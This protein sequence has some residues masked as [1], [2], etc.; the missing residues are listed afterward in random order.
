VFTAFFQR[1]YYSFKRNFAA[2]IMPLAFPLIFLF[3]FLD[4]AGDAEKAPSLRIAIIEGQLPLVVIDSLIET[5]LIDLKYIAQDYELNNINT[6][7]FDAILVSNYAANDDIVS[8]K[9]NLTLLTRTGYSRWIK[10]I[11]SQVHISDPGLKELDIVEL[12]STGNSYIAFILPGLF[13]MILIQLATTST[14]NLILSD[15]QDGTLR[16]I[17]SVK[18]SIFPLFSAEI[19][20]RFIFTM[21]CY[22][23]IALL[24]TQITDFLS[25][26]NFIQFTAV[27]ILG[28]FMMMILGFALGGV[29]PGQRNWSV[30]ITLL[31]LSFWFFSDILFVASQH[32]F[33]K[34][35]SL[36]LPPT[37][38]VDALRQIST[39]EKGTFS[40]S[41]DIGMIIFWIVLLSFISIKFFRY[42]TNDN[43]L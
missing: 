9:D 3:L 8:N 1:S 17:S 40:L 27:F 10:A 12:N 41:F 38:L 23:L 30:L 13:V 37:Y 15:R 14:A 42:E 4:T 11:L 34:P 24:A 5:S 36:I 2:G 16:I 25:E 20:F 32:A 29:L 26:G 18:N 31:G 22:F 33:A 7:K 28:A 39:G 43:R 19:A 21:T 6:K 35:L